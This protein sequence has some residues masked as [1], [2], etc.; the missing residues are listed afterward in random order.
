MITTLDVETT[1]QEGD[2]S[3]YNENNKLVSVG[4]NQEYYFFNHKDN[5]NGHDNF[6]KIQA[7]LDESTLVIGHNLKFDLSW[8]YWQGW[9]YKGDI[10][11]TMLGEYIIRRGQKVDEHNKLISL[12]LFI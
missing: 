5:P 1:Y 3:P 7:I 9:K 12:S 8:M 11:D 2:P 10:Y 4:I 6:D